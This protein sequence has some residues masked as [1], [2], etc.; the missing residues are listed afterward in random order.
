[1]EDVFKSS[2][3]SDTDAY[4]QRMLQDSEKAYM[5]A[6][7]VLA[8]A[9]GGA[10]QPRDVEVRRMWD[11]IFVPTYPCPRERRIGR[12]GDG[13]KWTCILKAFFAKPKITVFSI[14]SHGDPSFE[15]AVQKII[16]AKP[17]TFDPFLNAS[18]LAEMQSQPFM[19]FRN[20][21]LVGSRTKAN[22]TRHFPGVTF[23]T[24]EEGMQQAGRDYIDIFKIDCEGCEYPVLDDLMERYT[25]RRNPPI[26]QLL[27]EFHG[28]STQ[29]VMEKYFYGIQ[30]MGFRLFHVER[31][32]YF[33]NFCAEFSF[34]HESLLPVEKDDGITY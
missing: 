1:M 27:V 14:G 20:A 19:R 25:A 32:A 15:Q 21:G 2:D 11:F 29:A 12:A 8:E 28:A 6:T 22:A 17:Y 9:F 24:L 23:V 13:G 18:T 26:G 31:N 5:E 34:I 30:N 4:E 33:P 10:T 7:A 3:C 16:H